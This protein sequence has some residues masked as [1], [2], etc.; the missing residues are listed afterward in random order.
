MNS[1]WDQG[2]EEEAK[3]AA[4]SAKSWSIAAIVTG[5]IPVVVIIIYEVAHAYS[6]IYANDDYNTYNNY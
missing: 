4:A 1:L 3:R 6:F 2:K 5:A